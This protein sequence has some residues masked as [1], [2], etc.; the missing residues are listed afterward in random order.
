MRFRRSTNVGNTH[1]TIRCCAP[2]WRHRETSKGEAWHKRP[3]PRPFCLPCTRQNG[4]RCFV[5]LQGLGEFSWLFKRAGR[6]KHV[7]ES[8][9]AEQRKKRNRLRAVSF[10][11][12]DVWLLVPAGGLAAL[13][14]LGLGRGQPASDLPSLLVADVEGGRVFAFARQPG[15]RHVVVAGKGDEV[16]LRGG[17]HVVGAM[18]QVDLVEVARNA[19]DG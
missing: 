2:F 19:L 18:D 3:M 14:W 11:R 6:A 12:G 16:F 17:K 5:Q 15:R 10:F 7:W 1:E 13:G 4:A 9:S 8:C